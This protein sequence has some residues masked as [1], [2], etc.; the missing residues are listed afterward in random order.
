MTVK[1]DAVILLGHGSR[2]KSANEPLLKMAQMICELL[3][4]VRVYP[5]YL[6]L[7]EPSVAQSAVKAIG[8]GAKNIA[9]MPFFLFPGAHVLED[10]PAELEK[11]AGENN[12]V[13]FTLCSH[14]GLHPKI[15]EA[16]A[17]RIKESLN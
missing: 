11:I 13:K 6:Q 5:A 16:A 10:I 15:A 2:L 7:A 14:L 1:Y 4:G 8:D 3:D 17:E 9:V 12:H